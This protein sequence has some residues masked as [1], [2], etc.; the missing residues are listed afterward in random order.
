[1]KLTS[2]KK[3]IM[4]TIFASCVTIT[5]VGCENGNI[6]INNL[7]SDTI[8]ENKSSGDEELVSKEEILK[9]EN[10]EVYKYNESGKIIIIMYHKFA[11]EEK[12]EWTRSFDNFYGD[13]LYLYEHGYRTISLS[14][15]INN[16]I[17]V[18]VG[19][20]P[21]ILTFDDGTK[22]QFSFI[23]SEEGDLM[24]N[25]KSAVGVME[26]FYEKYPDFGLN[27]T[28]YI[29][30]TGYFGTIGTKKEKLQYLINKGFEIGNHT[31]THINFS[32]VTEREEIIK[33]V[34]ML[35]K[36]VYELTGYKINSL[37]LPFGSMS[38]TYENDIIKGVFE[39]GEYENK[40]LLLVGANPALGPSNEKLNLMRLPRVRA[41]G[42]NK[43]VQY[44]LYWW[45]EKMEKDPEMKYYRLDKEE[46]TN[47]KN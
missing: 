35:S 36:D 13:L 3:L 18:P 16:D 2:M 1:M 4:L 15:Y 9:E 21:V 43:E 25:P 24:V 17:K 19:C 26:K 14:D 32:K 30:Q 31:S 22:G 11:E 40:A 38:K 8:I 7:D 27:G 5:L 29:N 46:S 44:D 34:G 45:L 28:F 41:R 20:T 47:T 12:D 42:G 10:E 23:E 39:D 33:E 37:A 6:Q